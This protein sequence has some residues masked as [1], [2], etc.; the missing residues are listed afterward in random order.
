[1]AGTHSPH[2]ATSQPKPTASGRSFRGPALPKAGT[3]RNPPAGFQPSSVT[4]VG[5]H[6]GYLGAVLGQ[7]PCGGRSCTAIAGTTTYGGPWTTVGV[8]PAGAAAVSQLRFADPE[9]G[10]AYGPALYATHDGGLHWTRVAMVTG[11]VIDLAA[12]GGRVLAVTA[13]G[14]AGTGSG[15]AA[16]APCTGFGLYAA[17][18]GSDHFVR[19]LS[20]PG[21][22]PVTAG[23]LQLQPTVQAGYLIAGGRLYSGALDGGS[24]GLIPPESSAAPGC[25]TGQATGSP[26]LLAPGAHVL[27]LACATAQRLELYRSA[28]SGRTWQAAGRIPA[29]GTAT[30]LAVSPSGT[31]VLATT[32]GL[33]SSSSAAPAW[34]PAAG[35]SGS[36]VAFR[37][38]GMT[39]ARLGVALPASDRTARESTS[40]ATA[41][42]PGGQRDQP[43]KSPA[44]TRR[45]RS[46]PNSS[47]S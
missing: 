15:T 18:V 32:D 45:L 35:G 19:V 10:W 21:G 36:G 7:A 4:F 24:W 33:Y 6:G 8:S 11:R 39:T 16:T 44:A 2:R 9:N 30:S 17:A 14:C 12:A 34:K 20:G 3:G 42:A 25:L 23:G 40:P 46:R 13:T 29:T 22:G 41:A 31:L 5:N 47:S 28:S 43:V 37:Y 38:V 27:Y 26:A 1:M